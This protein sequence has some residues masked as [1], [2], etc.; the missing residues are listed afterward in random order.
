M[1]NPQQSDEDFDLSF[2][3]FQKIVQATPKVLSN[4]PAVVQGFLDCEDED[5]AKKYVMGHIDALNPAFAQGILNASLGELEDATREAAIKQEIRKKWDSAKADIL[6]L[7]D[8][9][10]VDLINDSSPRLI[11]G[12]L[13]QELHRS[14]EVNT[15]RAVLKALRIP[16]QI[17]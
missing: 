8:H 14:H 6:W 9:G 1:P 5:E 17:E 13:N 2:S 16:C 4:D 3:D 15:V 12:F 10:G 11:C 7:K